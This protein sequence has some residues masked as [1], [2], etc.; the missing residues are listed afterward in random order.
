MPRRIFVVGHKN[1]DTD[2]IF[3]ALA[4]TELL[5][6]QRE[7]DVIAARQGEV[8]RETRY[9]LERFGLPLPILV[10]DVR[11]AARDVMTT[12]PIVGHAEESAYHVG[13][14]L[15]DDHTQFANAFGQ[16]LTSPHSITLGGI[17]SRKKQVVPALPRVARQPRVYG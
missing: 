17:M 3:S 15:R 12:Q 2:S 8:W 14:R 16:E 1:P 9:V 4:H 10:S 7:Q 6:L 11:P 13:W 5:R